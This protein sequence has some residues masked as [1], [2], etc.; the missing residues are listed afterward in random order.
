MLYQ[1]LKI[2]CDEAQNNQFTQ[3]L[4]FHI[5]HVSWPCCYFILVILLPCCHVSRYEKL[6]LHSHVSLLPFTSNSSMKQTELRMLHMY[7][8]VTMAWWH[9]WCICWWNEMQFV[10]A[11][12]LECYSPPP[13]EKSCPEIWKAYHLV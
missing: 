7:V 6:V 1:F 10:E 8:S 9:R 5:S 3:M 2:T 13:L 11:K 12:H 4:Q